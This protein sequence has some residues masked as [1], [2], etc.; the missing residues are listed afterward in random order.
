MTAIPTLFKIAIL[1]QASGY[2]ND[3]FSCKAGDRSTI[4]L[5]AGQTKMIKKK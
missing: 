4:L 5:T 2:K 3:S 1:K